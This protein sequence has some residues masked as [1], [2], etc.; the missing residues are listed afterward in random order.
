M[1]HCFLSP[2]GVQF[3][4]ILFGYWQAYVVLSDLFNLIVIILKRTV[5]IIFS[6]IGHEY[7][8]FSSEFKHADMNIA[9]LLYSVR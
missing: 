6:Y 3:L 1:L 2:S 9:S 5:D 7:F 8:L 4:V